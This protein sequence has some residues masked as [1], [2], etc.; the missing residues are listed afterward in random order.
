MFNLRSLE[1]AGGAVETE[2]IVFTFSERAG[3]ADDSGGVFIL[4]EWV[5]VDVRKCQVQ[6]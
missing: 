4:L 2:G 1:W 5:D 6:G 3:I